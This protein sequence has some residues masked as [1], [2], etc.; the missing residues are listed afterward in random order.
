MRRALL[1]SSPEYFS[2]VILIWGV[3][4]LS[5]VSH[6]VLLY[7]VKS[8]AF[9]LSG[10]DNQL[11]VSCG[12]G[13]LPV[14][15]CVRGTTLCGCGLWVVTGCGSR[16]VMG[17]SPA[18]PGVGSE[19]NICR[20]VG[21]VYLLNSH[22]YFAMVGNTIDTVT[23]VLTQRELDS[24][25][26]LFKILIELPD[27]NATIKDSP[28]GKIGMY[29]RL[30]EFANFRVPL[31]K[32]LLCV[33]EYY[34]INLAQLSVIS[35]AKFNGV[36]VVK[37]PLPLDGDVDFPCV[38]LLNENQ[39]GLLDFVKSADPLK[40]KIGERNL[41]D[42]EVP[43]LEE[44][45]DKVSSPSAQPLRLIDHTIKDELKANTG[46]RKR[47]V[48]FDAPCEEGAE[49]GTAPHPSEELVSSSVTH[50]PEPDVP[51]E[52]GETPDVNVQT[53]RVHE[54]DIAKTS[55]SAPG[56]GSPIDEFYES[57][58]IDSATAQ[59]VYTGA[60]FLDSFNINSAQHVC[61]VYEL[62]L[63]YE[64][65]IRSKERFQ[66]KFTES[67]VLRDRVSELET[68][69]VA[70]SEEVAGLNKQNVKLLRKVSTL[71]SVREELSNQVPK[72]GVDCESLRGKIAGEAKLREEFAL[73]QDAAARCFEEQSA[74]L[75]ARIADAGVEHGK[76]GRSL[77]QVEA[78]DP[79]AESKYVAAVNDFEI[80][81]LSLLEELEAL[82]YSPIA[83]IMSALALDGDVD[84][85]PRLRELQPS[86]DQETVHAYS[87]SSCSRGRG[88]VPSSNFTE[89]GVA[90]AV[91]IQDLLQII[92][93]LPWPTLEIRHRV[94]SRL[95]MV[96]KLTRRETKVLPLPHTVPPISGPSFRYLCTF[97]SL[98]CSL[99]LE[100]RLFPA[101][102]RGYLCSPRRKA[103]VKPIISSTDLGMFSF[104]LFNSE[105]LE[106]VVHCITRSM[107]SVFNVSNHDPEIL[108]H[109]SRDSHAFWSPVDMHAFCFEPLHEGFRR[110]PL[111]LFDVVNFYGVLDVFLLLR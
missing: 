107:M 84:S 88:L 68:E 102:L 76:A 13:M 72:L 3:D 59:D 37:D 103:V 32:F 93:F 16:L 54:R 104:S 71:E 7:S 87:E 60:R 31:S 27:L 109:K 67:S 1:R 39:M 51:E 85:I 101:L 110:F 92:K 79:D 108:M 50:T 2:F 70:K 45:E 35:V 34:Q 36:S 69:V 97:T 14:A 5:L 75:D 56:E 86:L 48:V 73:L 46:K 19:L 81:S 98:F 47:K 44:T 24:H 22:P 8:R 106:R 94:L 20:L 65:E 89:G 82:K 57:Q 52:S 10:S 21:F 91:T 42:N 58:T 83:P 6:A 43:L 80:F 63:R 74:Q 17:R 111:L 4:V 38:E 62:R 100:S 29:T 12:Y 61:M 99:L 53:R 66:G 9:L 25:C 41:A 11:Q 15:R 40:V 105:W 90:R 78:Y 96:G 64:H 18:L 49:S 77:A 28:M 55:A 23:S 33:L 26:S 95:T 30:L